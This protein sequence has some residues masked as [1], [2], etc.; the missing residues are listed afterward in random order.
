[1][2][3]VKHAM[4]P[5]RRSDRPGYYYGLT[6]RRSFALACSRWSAGCI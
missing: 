6:R 4:T 3:G 5:R 1:M 2:M